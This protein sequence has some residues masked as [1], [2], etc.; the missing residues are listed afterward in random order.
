MISLHIVGG[1]LLD[2]ELLQHSVEVCG[3]PGTGTVCSAQSAAEATVAGA[4]ALFAA[5]F[6]ALLLQVR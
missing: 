4:A 6:A 1:F 3:A 5:V 2:K